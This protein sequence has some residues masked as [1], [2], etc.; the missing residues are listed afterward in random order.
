MRRILQLA[1]LAPVI[2]EAILSGNEPSGLSL[3]KLTKQ[4][5]MLWAEQREYLVIK[6]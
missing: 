2:V 5:P 6:K 1:L 4:L 3:E